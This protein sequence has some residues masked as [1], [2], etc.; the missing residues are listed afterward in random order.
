MAGTTQKAKPMGNPKSLYGISPL[1]KRN[2]PSHDKKIFTR[3]GKLK[4]NGTQQKTTIMATSAFLSQKCLSRS[5]FIITGKDFS[6][7]IIASF[8]LKNA[9]DIE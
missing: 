2:A 6:F 4:N 9:T 5:D 3:Y 8:N 1:Y 7:I